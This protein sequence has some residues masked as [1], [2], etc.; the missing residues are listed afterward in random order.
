[1]RIVPVAALLVVLFCHATFAAP[2]DLWA[3]RNFVEREM[4]RTARVDFAEDF[5][6]HG[7]STETLELLARCR[8]ADADSC[9]KRAELLAEKLR[10]PDVN[11]IRAATTTTLVQS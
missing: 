1:M 11:D 4:F 8:M 5:E 2:A 10:V 6:E 3:V 9:Q 7:E